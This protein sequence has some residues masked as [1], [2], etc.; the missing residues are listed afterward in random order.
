M[1]VL[2]DWNNH[3]RIRLNRIQR[4]KEITN[5]RHCS[6]RTR[7]FK[8]NAYAPATIYGH[9]KANMNGI[10]SSYDEEKRKLR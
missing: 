10:T 2:C 5:I 4:Y 7:K 9:K 3:L 1:G 6:Q 8:L